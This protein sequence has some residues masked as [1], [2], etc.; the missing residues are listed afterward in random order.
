MKLICDFWEE[1]DYACYFNGNLECNINYDYEN[2]N[3]QFNKLNVPFHAC[4][5]NELIYDNEYFANISKNSKHIYLKNININ[6]Y[7]QVSFLDRL[8]LFTICVNMFQKCVK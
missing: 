3:I 5:D 2:T 8:I 7:K 4:S 6:T 1:G